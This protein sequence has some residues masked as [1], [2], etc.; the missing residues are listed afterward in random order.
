[1]A[2]KIFTITLKT[3]SE[4]FGM[5]AS[6]LE[7]LKEKVRSKFKLE[8]FLVKL[9]DG[10]IVDDE[11]YFQCLDAATNLVIATGRSPECDDELDG[12]LEEENSGLSAVIKSLQDDI[13]KVTILS[14]KQL[15]LLVDAD[16]A[17]LKKELN[18]TSDEVDG[19]QDACN[20][21]LDEIQKT[22]DA[23]E[24]LKLFRKY[25]EEPSV[26]GEQRTVVC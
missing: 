13:S 11:D 12:K 3:S 23:L 25:T 20:T 14:Q 24:L 19:L 17:R 5:G 4:K 1:M 6:S 18:L 21:H 15:S 8:D 7:Q 26:T 10:T 2:T 16:S 22:S 9:A